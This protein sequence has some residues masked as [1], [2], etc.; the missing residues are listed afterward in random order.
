MSELAAD[1][2]EEETDDPCRKS[3]CLAVTYQC[4]WKCDYCCVDTHN[5]VEPTFER[6][7]ELANRVE[8]GMHVSLTGGEPGMMDEEL[9]IK[10]LDLFEAKG[11][12][13]GVNT[14][15]LFFIK[16]PHHMHRINDYRYHCSEDLTNKIYIPEGY[17]NLNIKFLVVVTDK[18]FGNLQKF[19]DKNPGI[20][21]VIYSA[22]QH[23]V[24]GKPGA[25]L[26]SANRIKL[27]QQ[28]KDRIRLDQIEYLFNRNNQT[29]GCRNLVRL[30]DRHIKD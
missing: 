6:V 19:L 14:N 20:D 18:N 16:Y 5:R 23:I 21:F 3:Y 10:L 22:D 29:S 17:E 11:C 4:N 13:I 7:M 15:G 9:L 1:L 8:P 26:S 2:L 25:K 30:N 12:I 28:F 24:N 27:Y